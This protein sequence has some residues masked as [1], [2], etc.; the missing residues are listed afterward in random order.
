MCEGWSNHGPRRIGAQNGQPAPFRDDHGSIA[1][2]S[3]AQEMPGAGSVASTRQERSYGDLSNRVTIS[4]VARTTPMP[5][6]NPVKKPAR[7]FSRQE[8]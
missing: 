6:A 7:K 4:I 5:H 1:A 3:S 2:P 8:A